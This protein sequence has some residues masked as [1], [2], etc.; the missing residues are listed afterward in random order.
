MVRSQRKTKKTAAKNES[1]A[2]QSATATKSDDSLER[3]FSSSKSKP[4]SSTLINPEE[5]ESS[6]GICQFYE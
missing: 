5:D 6:T 4:T 3:D 1:T 2:N